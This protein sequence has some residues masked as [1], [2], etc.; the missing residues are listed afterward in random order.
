MTLLGNTSDDDH[1]DYDTVGDARFCS[2]HQPALFQCAQQRI[3]GTG[4]VGKMQ[5]PRHPIPTF[6]AGKILK[7][8]QNLE[9]YS[10]GKVFEKKLKSPKIIK[11][12][13][14]KNR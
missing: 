5:E 9:K 7:N 6:F 2:I 12:K 13:V 8:T 1:D 4:I 10:K 3:H 11:K 14:R